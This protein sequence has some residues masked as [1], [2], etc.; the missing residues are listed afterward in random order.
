M[1]IVPAAI[2]FLVLVN[3]LCLDQ[4]VNT[5]QVVCDGDAM[6][7]EELRNYLLK[8]K[9][10]EDHHYKPCQPFYQRPGKKHHYY[11]KRFLTELL[12]YNIKLFVIVCVY[13]IARCYFELGG[14][15]LC[16]VLWLCC[17]VW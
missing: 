10:S 15:L 5:P 11:A 9:M 6:L 14:V 12:C 1:T 8:N 4:G 7:Q 2:L 3:K 16:D 17:L 13:I